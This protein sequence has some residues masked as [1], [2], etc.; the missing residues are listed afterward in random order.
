MT[1]HTDQKLSVAD[2]P[3]GALNVLVPIRIDVDLTPSTVVA[4]DTVDLITLPA[5]STVLSANAVVTTAGGGA[6]TVDIGVTGGDVDGILDGIDMNNTAGTVTGTPGALVGETYVAET[7][8]SALAI[9]A[10]LGKFSLF[11]VVA[12]C[13]VV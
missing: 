6:C 13:K 2:N 11:L 3:Q 12:T 8:L 5:G 7:T 4:A 10:A 1:A 9:T